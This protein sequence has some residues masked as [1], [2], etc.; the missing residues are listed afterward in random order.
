MLY[1]LRLQ[2]A[3]EILRKG[4]VSG[5]CKVD[6]VEGEVDVP[7]TGIHAGNMQPVGKA[8][9]CISQAKGFTNQLIVIDPG[10]PFHRRRANQQNLWEM[11]TYLAEKRLH[12]TGG[13]LSGGTLK[14]VI[15]TQHNQKQIHRGLFFPKTQSTR[16]MGDPLPVDT[17]VDHSVAGLPG[18]QIHP[19]VFGIITPAK[20]IPG[21]IAI[22]I[23]IAK[24]QYPQ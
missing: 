1:M 22:G 20:E 23:G 5:F 9:I 6:T 24:A 4:M 12:T 10:T 16:E 3:S 17:G 19:A 14:Q 15:G 2:L 8:L 7:V 11:G 21:I 18:Q 13:F